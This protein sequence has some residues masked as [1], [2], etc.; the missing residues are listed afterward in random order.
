MFDQLRTCDL[1]IFGYMRHNNYRD[2]LF[3]SKIYKKRSAL[4][5]LDDSAGQRI[6]RF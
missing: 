1:A 4:S 5:N 3:F 2:I 6:N